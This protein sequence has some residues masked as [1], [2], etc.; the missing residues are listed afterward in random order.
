MAVYELSM[1]RI[2][3]AYFTPEE[4][5]GE[6]QE[7]S[8]TER[9]AIFAQA[10]IRR[11]DPLF[12]KA[13]MRFEE[14]QRVIIMQAARS[15]G[16]PD[17][18][19]N[20]AEILEMRAAETLERAAHASTPT[21]S[22]LLYVRASQDLMRA[23]KR[24]DA[25]LEKAR[26]KLTALSLINVKDPKRLLPHAVVLEI[27]RHILERN[28]LPS[29]ERVTPFLSS[30]P[31][32]IRD[33]A[34]LLSE[35]ERSSLLRALPQSS[36]KK[37]IQLIDASLAEVL[38]PSYDL[39][40]T[41]QE[42][43]QK[44]RAR[45]AF[46]LND[47]VSTRRADDLSLVKILSQSLAILGDDTKQ[48]I[49]DVIRTEENAQRTQRRTRTGDHLPR[50]LKSF[51]DHFSDWRGNDIALR[52]AGDRALSPHLSWYLLRKLVEQNYLPPDL[53]EW[54][55]DGKKKELPASTNTA[56]SAIMRKREDAKLQ[57]LRAVI[58]DLGVP[59]SSEICRYIED[60]TRWKR[61]GALFTKKSVIPLSERLAEIIKRKKEFDAFG[62]VH[63]IASALS[64][65]RERALLFYMLFGG[66][67]R[68]DLINNYPFEKFID[69]CSLIDKLKIHEQPLYQFHTAL[70][71]TG[72]S[73]VEIDKI[74]T[75]LTQGHT[76][77]PG[78]HS[79]EQVVSFDIRTS[80]QVQTANYALGNTLSRRQAGALLLTPLYRSYLREYELS[81]HRAHELLSNLEGA[82]LVEGRHAVLSTIEAA[83]P[84]F[85]DRAEEYLTT[86]WRMGGDK[87]PSSVRLSDVLRSD[88]NAIDGLRLVQDVESLRD[89]LTT[90]LR[91]AEHELETTTQPLKA[92]EAELKRKTKNLK[93]LGVGLEKQTDPER[94]AKLEEK[95]EELQ[96][97]CERLQ[98]Q[99]RTREALLETSD[100]GSPMTGTEE[101]E[102]T[103]LRD[104]LRRIEK[105]SSQ[106]HAEIIADLFKDLIGPTHLEMDDSALIDDVKANI[107]GTLDIL[108]E[109]QDKISGVDERIATKEL[110]IRYLD[111][112]ERFMA[113]V[114]FAD[115]ASCC[116]S[117]KEYSLI[118][119]N[120]HNV[121]NKWWVASIA[122][123]PLS[124]VFSLEEAA[125]IEEGDLN[126][127][128]HKNEGF[129]F[130]SFGIT[131]QNDLA[132]LANGIYYR[133]GIQKQEQFAKIMDAVERHLAGLP[134]S[135]LGLKV[136]L[137]LIRRECVPAA[138]INNA[139]QLRRLRA[140]DDD[141]GKPEQRI[142]DDLGRQINT[143]LTYG[144]EKPMNNTKPRFRFFWKQL[145][146]QR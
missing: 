82:Q 69:M 143:L 94:R 26:K 71:H 106:A 73:Q 75:R 57:I 89:R 6:T 68:F 99:L 122:A 112:K 130:C 66:Q 146:R 16:E 76:P 87:P 55:E 140:L 126:R 132:V 72:M 27:D 25:A 20:T 103:T 134:V 51:L 79:A 34:V 35:K 18:Q 119:P 44:V 117:S 111:K 97:E 31:R 52:L 121:E 93:N 33:Y 65:D 59:P 28:P 78:A 19:G 17:D 125:A 41:E 105:K 67:D 91:T 137:E 81:D 43:R 102:L 83:Y 135:I 80:E 110:A 45:L 96:H 90:T 88:H 84:S 42:Q 4:N 129:I 123:D 39:G 70:A 61:K 63:E 127:T 29:L 21:L 133:P 131:P 98:Q 24:F 145:E 139:I 144:D 58:T 36:R 100:A 23:D 10:D 37:T 107:I 85:L 7:L 47:T 22:G 86:R 120:T 64:A 101:N 113:L 2:E 3:G 142:Y 56:E 115:S 138:Y 114:R 60:D 128:V 53:Q 8:Q 95:V 109:A 30:D 74:V 1:K 108:S 124:F 48:L 116:F 11:R 104:R 77:L 54:W 118:V 49:L 50:V 40:D 13:L 46:E 32:L 136:D 38:T 9:W 92:L 15:E 62:S 12:Q 5:F 14:E 141:H